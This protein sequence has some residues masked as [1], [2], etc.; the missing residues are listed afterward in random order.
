MAFTQSERPTHVVMLNSAAARTLYPKVRIVVLDDDDFPP[1]VEGEY[2]IAV[3]RDYRSEHGQNAIS[4]IVYECIR[5]NFNRRTAIEGPDAP[6]ML[7]ESL[8]RPSVQRIAAI[9]ELGYNVVARHHS[10]RSSVVTGST[11]P[12]GMDVGDL[13]TVHELISCVSHALRSVPSSKFQMES[14]LDAA[15]RALKRNHRRTYKDTFSARAEEHNGT[16]YVRINGKRTMTHGP[17]AKVPAERPLCVVASG[18]YAGLMLMGGQRDLTLLANM[19]PESFIG[20]IEE[21]T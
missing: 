17:D 8:Q 1:P 20:K 15:R 12:C 4:R 3:L 21:I 11:T 13:A 5:N 19:W 6:I 9:R 10:G 14:G 7:L 16:N 18:E 2:N